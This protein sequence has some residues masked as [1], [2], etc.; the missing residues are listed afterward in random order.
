MI[1]GKTQMEYIDLPWYLFPAAGSSRLW[2]QCTTLGFSF[3]HAPESKAPLNALM[4]IQSRANNSPEPLF[5]CNYFNQ[6]FQFKDCIRVCQQRKA[7]CFNTWWPCKLSLVFNQI[8][9]SWFPVSPPR[10]LET[11]LFFYSHLSSKQTG[12]AGVDTLP[13]V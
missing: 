1:C 3:P 2:I 12:V 4:S 10:S 8:Q 9:R 7:N 6:L 11:L 13:F 5:H